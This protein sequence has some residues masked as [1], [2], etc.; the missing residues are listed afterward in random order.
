MNDYQSVCLLRRVYLD[1]LNSPD[2]AVRVVKDSGST[3]GANMVARYMYTSRKTRKCHQNV[4]P[5]LI[6]SPLTDPFHRFFQKM[7]DYSSALQFLVLSKC[8]DEA[9]AMA[10]V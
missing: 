6:H 4:F 9:F 8:N 1:Q 3:E 7:G 5:I 2:D 10:E